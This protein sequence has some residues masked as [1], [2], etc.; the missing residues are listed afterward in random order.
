MKKIINLVVPIG[1]VIVLF[2][3]IL[4]STLP[5][6]AI[7]N[8]SN[9]THEISGPAQDGPPW[10]DPAWHYRRA[11]LITNSGA[12]L[13]YYQVLVKLDTNNFDFSRTKPDGADLRFTHSDGTTELKFWIESWDSVN[14]L[15]YVWVRV[16]S[17]SAGETTIYT[18]FNNPAANPVGD[19]NT[20]FDSFDDN[21]NQFNPEGLIRAAE[22]QVKGNV[23]GLY[24]PFSWDIISGIPDA[25]GGILSIADGTGIKSTSSY[26]YRAVG[27]RANYSLNS[28]DE[29]MGFIDGINGPRTLI[30][31]YKTG[32]VD[33]LYLQDSQNGTIFEYLVIPK[34]GGENWHGDY[35]VYEVR[36]K[37]N[38]SSGD[39]DH[40]ASGVTS[41]MPETVPSISLP[42]SLY[43]DTDSGGTLLVDWVYVRQFRDP[44]PTSSV[45]PEQGLVELSIGNTDEPD[46]VLPATRL[47]YQLTISNT[48][49]IEA[50][51]VVV[52]DTLPAG[53]EIAEVITSK[54]SCDRG[55][56]VFCYIPSIGAHSTEWVT[57]VVTTTNGGEITNTAEVGSPGYELDLSDN[58]SQQTTLVDEEPPVVNWERPVGPG[59]TF[60]TFGGLVTL[61]ASATDVGGVAWVEFKLWDH[62]GNT[63]VSI[64]KS[65]SY[66]YQV[67]F[68]SNIL[69]I[70]EIYQMFVIGADRAG[71]QTPLDPQQRIFIERKISVYLPLLRK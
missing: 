8:N 52:T 17:V 40:G 3:I 36:W 24:S 1:L 23:K 14:Q 25:S 59:G 30:S 35:H 65:Y 34:V 58:F 37:S 64:G 69:V 49:S 44:E 39:I 22:T 38:E 50:P 41:T 54:G 19:G 45:Y 2:I 68:D 63:W 48:A 15:A 18:Y 27:L 47:T 55:S 31:D 66:P 62:I 13:P 60:S 6:K 43:N 70:N 12:S 4:T 20:T 61:E 11:V 21:W 16:P 10:F 33:D 67:P 46:P 7:S 26:L 29:W 32:N 5:A 51:T 53:V 56:I 57:I 42:V 9:S 71:N 28:T